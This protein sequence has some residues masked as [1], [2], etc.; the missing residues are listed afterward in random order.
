MK[1]RPVSGSDL[2]P[3]QISAL[4]TSI[5]EQWNT[6]NNILTDD[7]NRALIGNE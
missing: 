2:T 6:V 5:I 4:D 1:Q 7:F 3:E